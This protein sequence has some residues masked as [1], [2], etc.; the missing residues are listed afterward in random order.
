MG[1]APIEVNT[2][3]GVPTV[4]VYVEFFIQYDTLV[5]SRQAD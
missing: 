1:I 2:P 5:I 3:H 4:R